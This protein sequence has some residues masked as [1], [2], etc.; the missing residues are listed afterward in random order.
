V[1]VAS[2]GPYDGRQE[3]HPV[4]KKLSNE[5]LIWLSVWTSF[6]TDN[7]ASTS[8]LNFFTDQMLFLTS[9][10]QCQN[11]E[12]TGVFISLNNW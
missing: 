10:K 2:A 3:E 1:A 6:Q 9:N 7:H 4:C 5:V 8:S 12:G 11:I